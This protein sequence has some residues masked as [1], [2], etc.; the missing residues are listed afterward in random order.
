MRFFLMNESFNSSKQM[1][2]SLPI[3]GFV[4]FEAVYRKTRTT[5]NYKQSAVRCETEA[6]TPIVSVGG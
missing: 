5:V 4:F 3:K 2:P 6:G 1:I